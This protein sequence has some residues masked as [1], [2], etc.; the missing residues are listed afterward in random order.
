MN[1]YIDEIDWIPKELA[2]KLKEMGLN[3]LLDIVTLPINALKELR[4]NR[5]D[6]RRRSNLIFIND[7][8]MFNDDRENLSKFYHAILHRGQN[9]GM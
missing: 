8:L 3:T 2:L 5:Q 4:L 6:F 7:E 1:Q 9:L